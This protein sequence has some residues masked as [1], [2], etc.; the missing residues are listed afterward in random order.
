MSYGIYFSICFYDPALRYFDYAYFDPSTHF[1]FAQCIAGSEAQEAVQDDLTQKQVQKILFSLLIQ[2]V[3]SAYLSLYFFAEFI[4]SKHL[5][6][7]FHREQFHQKI[8]GRNHVVRK[9]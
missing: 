7:I 9:N 2:F 8:E 3:H 4:G 5:H 1:D 6:H